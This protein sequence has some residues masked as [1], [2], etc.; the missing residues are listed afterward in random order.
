LLG[1]ALGNSLSRKA[2]T[3]NALTILGAIAL[4]AI[5]G[6]GGKKDKGLKIDADTKLSSGLRKPQNE[7]EVKKVQSTG[8]L[9][10]KA[11]VNAA[12]ADGKIDE[13]E[14]KRL[15]GNAEKDGVNKQAREWTPRR[16]CATRRTRR[17]QRRFTPLR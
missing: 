1:G 16:S 10:V 17:S 2:L 9:I 5:K 15:M 4:N 12:K 14:L 3:S 13:G 7:Q 8:E 11:M 6:A